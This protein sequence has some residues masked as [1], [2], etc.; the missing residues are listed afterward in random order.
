MY[1]TCTKVPLQASQS[2]KK[3]AC[4]TSRVLTHSEISLSSILYINGLLLTNPWLLF[5]NDY[6]SV[7]DSAL[8][9]FDIINKSDPYKNGYIISA[10]AIL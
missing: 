4:P 2:N 7:N 8:W 10:V 5:G 1:L 3:L 9:Y 6:I